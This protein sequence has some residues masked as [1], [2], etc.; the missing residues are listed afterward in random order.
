MFDLTVIAMGRLKERFY[1]DA[2]AEYAKR[3]GAYCRFTLRE[4]PEQPLPEDPSPAQIRQA[5]EREAAEI[6]KSV[7][8]GAWLAA[9]TPEGKELSSPELAETMARAKNGGK[10]SLCFVLGSSFGMADRVKT[11]A[12]LRISMGPMTFPHHLARVMLLEQL[13]RSYKIIEGSR[14]H[15]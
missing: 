4:L 13:Y 7:P 1:L 14:Y 8:K 11:K 12:D 3:L 15:K 2:A 9:F 6:E 5:L 10:N